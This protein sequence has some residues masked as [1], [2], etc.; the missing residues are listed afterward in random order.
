[1]KGGAEVLKPLV[2]ACLDDAPSKRPTITAVFKLLE[3]LKVSIST[4]MSSLSE[5]NILLRHYN[6]IVSLCSTKF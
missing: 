5:F 4:I 3:P 1:M 6:D 2:K